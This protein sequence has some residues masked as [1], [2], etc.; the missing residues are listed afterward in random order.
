MSIETVV[1]IAV[2]IPIS[3]EDKNKD[4]ETGLVDKIDYAAKK[5]VYDWS[6]A[7]RQGEIEVSGSELLQ[8]AVMF[9]LKNET[10]FNATLRG[11]DRIHSGMKL[12]IRTNLFGDEHLIRFKCNENGH[13]GEHYL[14][15]PFDEE[16]ALTIVKLSIRGESGGCIQNYNESC[17]LH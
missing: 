12:L 1:Y 9:R 16:Y 11:L 6:L 10:L 13:P 4:T 17:F 15:L 8:P 3:E 7:E 14:I 5:A 2:L